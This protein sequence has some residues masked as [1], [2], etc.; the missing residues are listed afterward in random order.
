[1]VS[2]FCKKKI[3]LI[4]F[5]VDV[6]ILPNFFVYILLCFKRHLL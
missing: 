4:Y 2:I 6:N 5:T 1:M 3:M